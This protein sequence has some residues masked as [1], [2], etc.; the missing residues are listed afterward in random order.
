M[1]AILCLAL[2]GQIRTID[3]GAFTYAVENTLID[4]QPRPVLLRHLVQEPL[5]TRIMLLGNAEYRFR[6][7]AYGD[8]KSDEYVPAL[9][10]GLRLRDME[11]R[12]LCRNLLRERLV[13]PVCVGQRRCFRYKGAGVTECEACGGSEWEHRR[14]FCSLCRGVGYLIDLEDWPLP[15]PFVSQD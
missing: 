10:V 8:L 15:K 12:F 4:W 1:T 3:D 7:L 6:M 14:D 13:C 2:L 11:C 9:V 5:A